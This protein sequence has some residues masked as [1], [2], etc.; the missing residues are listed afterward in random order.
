MTL[1]VPVL[2]LEVDPGLEK[3]ST[4]PRV[5]ITS[6]QEGEKNDQSIDCAAVA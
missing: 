6:P 2:F 4:N 1:T 3:T 5:T